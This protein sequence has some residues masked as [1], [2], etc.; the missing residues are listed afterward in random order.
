MSRVGPRL[1]ALPARCMRRL[2][3]AFVR[4]H[5]RG[6]AAGRRGVVLIQDVALG[7]VPANP[8]PRF[9][10]TFL[11]RRSAIQR[12]LHILLSRMREQSEMALHLGCGNHI[13]PGVIN[14][15]LHNPAAD[16]RIDSTRLDVFADGTVDLV[17]CH[18]MIEHLS[19]EA[20]E[21][22]IGEWSRVLRPLGRLVLTCPD[23][24]AV[25][26]R[27]LSSG[28]EARWNSGI[29][30]IYG[31]QEH[32]GMF[33]H[34][35]YDR[36]FLTEVLGRHGLDVEFAYTPFPERP[37]PSLLVIGRKGVRGD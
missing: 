22:A 32:P 30:M 5:N 36:A 21:R 27:W 17:E 24:P 9:P 8:T 16:R 2:A 3:N 12:D 28:P 29:R 10:R 33:H 18:H 19:F 1:S 20:A 34:S 7:P 13:I 4:P 35:G 31:S 6:V 37:T 11:R 15:D 23:L 26:R 25:L 14:C